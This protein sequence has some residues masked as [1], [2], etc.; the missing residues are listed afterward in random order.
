MP[1]RMQLGFD[2][3]W[4]SLFQTLGGPGS[5]PATRRNLDDMVRPT[6]LRIL[7]W[8]M[9]TGSFFGSLLMK[10]VFYQIHPFNS[11]LA[12]PRERLEMDKS[13]KK[14]RP[15]LCRIHISRFWFWMDCH[16]FDPHAGL[17]WISMDSHGFPWIF[18]EFWW[19]LMDF[20]GFPWICYE[21]WWIVMVFHEFGWVSMD[22]HGFSMNFVGF[23]WISYEFWWILMDFDEFCWISMNFD[24][25]SMNF[26]GF[27]WILD[28]FSICA[29]RPWSR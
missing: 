5:I 2:S 23:W 12:S 1:W 14:R 19:I 22:F 11:A 20:H 26:D 7:I 3:R 8:D 18:N 6:D 29:M 10:K 27:R 17:P 24:G 16:G 4:A 21:F 13:N 9:R 28:G 15:S 25:I